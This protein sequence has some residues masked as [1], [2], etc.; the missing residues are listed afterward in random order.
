VIGV[1][2]SNEENST[3]GVVLCVWGGGGGSGFVGAV[4]LAV[5]SSF[6]S[7]LVF[8]YQGTGIPG[9]CVAAD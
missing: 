3:V 5:H 7:A 6:G 4:V 2:I 1:F 8:L 9:P